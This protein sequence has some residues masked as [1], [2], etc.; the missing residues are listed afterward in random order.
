MSEDN[1]VPT[2]P[3]AR[4]G[5]PSPV[6]AG[7]RTQPIFTY[8]P[9]ATLAAAV[10][11]LRAHAGQPTFRT[12]AKRIEEAPLRSKS[13][14]LLSATASGHRLPTEDAIKA[15]A[16]A[17]YANDAQ[18]AVLLRLRDE[19]KVA[20]DG[21]LPNLSTVRSPKH[22]RDALVTLALKHIPGVERPRLGEAV[23]ERLAPAGGKKLEKRWTVTA[24]P[25]ERVAKELDGELPLTEETVANVVFAIGG[26]MEAIDYWRE[27]WQQLDHTQS[28]TA[29]GRWD[30]RRV[31]RTSG[32]IAAAIGVAAA[33]AL[34]HVLTSPQAS[35]AT[36]RPIPGS[37]S[38]RRPTPED[39]LLALR[40]HVEGLD[41]P[42]LFGRF[43]YTRITVWSWE[44]PTGDPMRAETSHEERLWWDEDLSGVHTVV[45]TLDGRRTTSRSTYGRGQAPV[46]I[47]K[48][49]A[50]P[51]ELA[52]Q[53]EA[54]YP[55]E[56]GPTGT[57]R[58]IAA[59]Y[60]CHALTP[61][62]RAATHDILAKTKGLR[63]EG[64]FPGNQLSIY[65]ETHGTGSRVDHDVLVFDRS[66]GA[67]LRHDMVS[68]SGRDGRPSR[69]LTS[70]VEFLEHG[71]TDRAG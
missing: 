35:R 68:V 66:D 40:D 47:P 1:A 4:R 43:T 59:I 22:L 46:T 21:L 61:A 33:P 58:G 65:A 9:G 49:S 69:E 18:T 39:H 28:V 3:P 54:E 41:E 64:V 20:L 71:R 36:L 8:G 31:L 2:T 60:G 29:R 16:K 27:A 12:M 63:Y 37:P 24:L 55:P 44:D 52:R 53:L 48:L 25:A 17:C 67:L 7:K 32:M 26:L 15:F 11:D 56:A 34:A 5:Q 62:Q 42:V 57:L 6:R 19:A 30:R 38:P 51:A 70:R 50:D 23:A 14:S 45:S 13:Q 10:R